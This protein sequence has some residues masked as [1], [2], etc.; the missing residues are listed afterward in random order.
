MTE[1]Q[2]DPDRNRFFLSSL[3]PISQTHSNIHTGLTRETGMTSSAYHRGNVH[4]NLV[5]KEKM[6]RCGR[7]QRW[8][9]IPL[10]SRN[11]VYFLTS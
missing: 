8:P 10:S 7:V 4:R 5:M 6:V 1:P 11:G 3:P 2:G 9:L